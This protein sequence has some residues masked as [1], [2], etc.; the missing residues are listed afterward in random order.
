MSRLPPGRYAGSTLPRPGRWHAD[1]CIVGAG[2]GGCAVAAALAAA[3]L[4]VVVLE[5]GRHWRPA[6]FKQNSSFALRNLYQQRGGRVMRGN[7]TM[8]LAG[9]R[10]VG[11]STLINSGI[12]F[13]CPDEVLRSWREIHGVQSADP[14]VFG[15]YFDR[16]W[17]TLG[18]TRQSLRIQGL[19]NTTFARGVEALG[20][21]GH[22]MDRSAPECVGCGAC[23]LGCAS[24]GKASADRTF[25][26]EALATGHVAVVADCRVEDVVTVS[27]RVVSVQGRII[28]PQSHA[29]VGRFTVE[30]DHFVLSAGPIG[31]PLLLQKSRLSDSPELGHHLVVHPTSSGL[32]RFDEP[33]RPWHGV[34]QGYYVDCWEE[35]YLLQSYTVTPDQYFLMLP[36]GAGDEAMEVMRDLK[37]FASAGALVHDEDSQGVVRS[38]PVG[39]DIWYDLGEGDK[40][41]LLAGLRRTGEVFLAAGARY[42]LPSI[43]GAKAATTVRGIHEQVPLDLPVE[44]LLSYASHP[45]GTCRMGGREKDSVVDPFGRVWGWRNLRVAD[46]SVFPTSLGVNPQVTTMAIGLMV[47]DHLASGA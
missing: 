2:A 33:I 39:P 6:D 12:C 9:G 40:Q 31:T 14:Q 32:A 18:V 17:E 21:Q 8:P 5:E 13:R 10:G 41:R 24:G 22:Y 38:T 35:G 46:A 45:M 3:G 26:A 25:L 42:F 37:Y 47:G 15:A 23:Q 43:R 16:I 34:T 20:L 30:A 4:N 19:N 29:P 11:G 28:D 27:D 36:M 7:A 44:R 1:V